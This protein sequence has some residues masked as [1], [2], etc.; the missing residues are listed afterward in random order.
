MMGLLGGGELLLS[1]EN[2][3]SGMR[4]TARRKHGRG[5]EGKSIYMYNMLIN[6]MTNKRRNQARR[7]MARP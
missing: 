4:Y 2:Y 5:A 1:L 6:T 3:D 7:I